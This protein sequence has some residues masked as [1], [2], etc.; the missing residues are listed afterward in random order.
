MDIAV[1]LVPS[2]LFGALSL[3]LGAFPTDTRRQNTAVMVGA[4]AV[5]LGCAALLGAP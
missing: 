1:A 3:L 5:S 2:L 4:G